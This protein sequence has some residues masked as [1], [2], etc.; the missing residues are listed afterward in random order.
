MARIPRRKLLII[1]GSVIVFLFIAIVLRLMYLITE[2]EKLLKT[3]INPIHEKIYN[4]FAN[5][6]EFYKVRTRAKDPIVDT[7]IHNI[8]NKPNSPTDNF[9]E[10]WKEVNSWVTKTQLTNFSSAKIGSVAQALKRGK[11]IYSDV[12]TRGTQLKLLLT[13][14][15]SFVKAFVAAI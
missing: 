14:E 8:N 11:I 2:S 5:L 3:P 9:K 15:V 1:L 13:L 10:L 6:P 7:F 4:H 12:D